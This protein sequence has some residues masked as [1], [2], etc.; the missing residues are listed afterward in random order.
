MAIDPARVARPLIETGL[1]PDTTLPRAKSGIHRDGGR[2]RGQS[3]TR[4][5]AGPKI[6]IAY[7]SIA[8]TARWWDVLAKLD[9]ASVGAGADTCR[10]CF[11]AAAMS[12]TRAADCRAVGER[13]RRLQN[14]DGGEERDAGRRE[15]NGAHDLISSTLDGRSARSP[16]P[17]RHDRE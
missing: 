1:V 11:A 14:H 10:I 17:K 7:A 16:W 2:D 15:E 6:V 13:R 5:I 8:R 3:S 9:R 12:D 4:S